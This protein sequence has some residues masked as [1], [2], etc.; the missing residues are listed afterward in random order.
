MFQVVRGCSRVFPAGFEHST[1]RV[2]F[3]PTTAQGSLPRGMR[4]SLSNFRSYNLLDS[5]SRTN[6]ICMD[7]S[8]HV[9]T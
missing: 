3:K 5:L 4:T 6:G 9:H 2:Y 1:F 7:Y 8:K